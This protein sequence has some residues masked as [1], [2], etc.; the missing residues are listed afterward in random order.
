MESYPPLQYRPRGEPP[1]TTRRVPRT[2]RSPSEDLPGVSRTPG[3]TGLPCPGE[4][5]KDHYPTHP[6]SSFVRRVVSEGSRVALRKTAEGRGG[7]ETRHRRDVTRGGHRSQRCTDCARTPSKL[8]RPLKEMEPNGKPTGHD[9]AVRR[10][11]KCPPSHSAA[12][13]TRTVDAT[14][15][16]QS[17]PAYSVFRRTPTPPVLALASGDR[18]RTTSPPFSDPGTNESHPTPG[19]VEGQR[20]GTEVWE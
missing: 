18:K 3:E 10:N 1:K 11:D 12:V 4:S 15:S 14:P 19:L 5:S 2:C 16:G 13:C 17:T 6:Q 8:P 9:L 7:V 20:C